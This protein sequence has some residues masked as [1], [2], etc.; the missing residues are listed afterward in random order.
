VDA[1][2]DFSH[3]EQM[4]LIIRHVKIIDNSKSSVEE[5][6]ICFDSFTKNIGQEIAL[7]ILELLENFELDFNKRVVQAYDNCAKLGGQYKCVQAI[8]LERN[9]N[10]ILSSCGNHTLNLVGVDSVESC[11]KAILYLGRIQQMYNFFSSSPRRWEILKKHVPVSLHAISKTRWSARINAVKPVVKHLSTIR[12]AVEGA[13]LL[14]LQPHARAGLQSIKE[15]LDTFECIPLSTI[16]IEM[17][18]LLQKQIY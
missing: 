6:F 8:L 10:C 14:N 9:P 1:T 16:W 13:E 15:Y 2:Q 18:T 5:R 12:A 17:L 3:K 11:K 4:C 7:R